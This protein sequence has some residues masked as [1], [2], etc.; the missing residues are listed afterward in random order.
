MALSVSI[1]SMLTFNS[2]YPGPSDTSATSERSRFQ[3]S[4]TF[5]PNCHNVIP[6]ILDSLDATSNKP[7]GGFESRD[8][9]NRL[10]H[11]PRLPV[12]HR[13]RTIIQLEDRCCRK[14]SVAL[15]MT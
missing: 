13:L 5:D 15:K 4:Y 2:K 9:K 10:I 14:A 6:I 11:N 1:K 7:V 12:A 8:H 3:Y